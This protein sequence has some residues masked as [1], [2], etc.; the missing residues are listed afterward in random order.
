M[1]FLIVLVFIS[2]VSC[3][4]E[5]NETESVLS[6]IDIE[7]YWIDYNNSSSGQGEI[8]GLTYKFASD[9]TVMI[10]YSYNYEPKNNFNAITS[11]ILPNVRENK[12]IKLYFE[13][14]WSI[15]NDN[16]IVIS[17]FQLS[18]NTTKLILDSENNLFHYSEFTNSPNTDREILKV[19]DTSLY[20]R[21]QNLQNYQLSQNDLN[22]IWLYDLNDNAF[23]FQNGSVFRYL[24]Y[25][26]GMPE[27]GF[28]EIPYN[29]HGVT[30]W[31]FSFQNFNNLGL[32]SGGNITDNLVLN[33][34]GINVFGDAFSV[35]GVIV[36]FGL[37]SNGDLNYLKFRDADGD[38]YNFLTE[39]LIKY[40]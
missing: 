15:I 6:E 5:N 39:F 29:N 1:K 24:E 33:E 8:E 18:S 20:G 31:Y 26:Q 7:G 23:D 19:Q 38:S 3:S 32:T 28:S 10:G 2:I 4:E 37:D 21:I 14:S 22:G 12:E 30:N 34:S 9:G 25:E 35:S 11:N 27:N 13:T 40:P 36:D 17:P 16:V